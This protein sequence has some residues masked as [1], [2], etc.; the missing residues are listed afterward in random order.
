MENLLVWSESLAPLPAGVI[1]RPP[2]GFPEQPPGAANAMSI[3]WHEV[4]PGTRVREERDD[5]AI[6]LPLEGAAVTASLASRLGGVRHAVVVDPAVCIAPPG[7]R[8]ELASERRSE[9][10][11]IALDAAQWSGRIQEALGLA[12]EIRDCQV[13]ADPFIRRIADLLCNSP[14]PQEASGGAWVD[15][16]AEDFAIHLATRYGRSAEAPAYAGLSPHRLQRVLGVI[17]ER[18]AGPI[19]V[20]DLAAEVHMSP[21]H[22][23]RMF[24]QSTGQAPHVYIT[25]QRMDRAKALLARTP[26]PLSEIATR[27][28]FRTQAHFTGVFHSRVGITPRAYR[29]RCRRVGARAA[30]PPLGAQERPG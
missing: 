15:A 13:V 12:P 30:Q 3:S 20:R 19:P 7:A 26:L 27:A 1:E 22:F 29:L 28:G 9:I 25:W 14:P 21:Y 6:L 18:L 10:L 17:E 4:G 23:A 8:L 5:V 16:V 11:V 2:P 24:K